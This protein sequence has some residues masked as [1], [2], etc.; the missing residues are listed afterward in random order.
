MIARL[1]PNGAF[2]A[3]DGGAGDPASV[4]ES[5]TNESRHGFLVISLSEA[6]WTRIGNHGADLSASLRS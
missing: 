1:R 5:V 4:R 6:P 2:L 3:V